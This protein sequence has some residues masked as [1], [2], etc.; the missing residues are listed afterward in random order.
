MTAGARVLPGPT[1][2]VTMCRRRQREALRGK[3]EI[4]PWCRGP[5]RVPRCERPACPRLAPQTASRN[6]LFGEGASSPA[7]GSSG[8]PHV[9]DIILLAGHSLRLRFA[10]PALTP[11]SSAR[12][13]GLAENSRTRS[14]SSERGLHRRHPRH[15]RARRLPP[16]CQEVLQASLAAHSR[17]S[18]LSREAP[19]KLRAQRKIVPGEGADRKCDRGIPPRRRCTRVRGS[20]LVS[21]NRPLISRRTPE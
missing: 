13:P 20:Q 9:A 5:A 18:P 16:S 4:P 8:H 10:F 2:I 19:P 6:P 1:P 7:A 3:T 17:G 14:C 12:L 21:N 15:A 11:K